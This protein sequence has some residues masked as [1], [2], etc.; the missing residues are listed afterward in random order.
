M[1]GLQKA[2]KYGALAFAAFLIISII[3]GIVG[4]LALMA[5]IFDNRDVINDTF[6]DLNINTNYNSLDI[7]LIS[8]NL[9]IKKGDTLKAETNNSNIS[10][11][12]E[13]NRI[14]IKE[15]KTGWFTNITGDLVI[16]VPTDLI[17]NDINIDS[18]AGKINIDFLIANQLELDLGAG[19]VKIDYLDV[20]KRGE[21]NGGAGEFSILNGHMNNMDFDLGV[22]KIVLTSNLIGTSKIDCGVGETNINLLGTKDDYQISID[23]GIGSITIN[24]ESVNGNTYYGNGINKVDIDGGIGSI[25]INF[26][27]ND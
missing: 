22:G 6:T 18:G 26:I 13:N 7:D 24:D 14:Y 11:K 1:S 12:Q 21:V 17:F 8:S 5:N 16:Y 20:L 15:K 27:T 4:G 23:K 25:N 3:G 2:I 9:T 10:I 19:N